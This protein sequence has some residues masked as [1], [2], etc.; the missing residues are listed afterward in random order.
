MALLFTAARI[1]RNARGRKDIL[2]RS[3]ARGVRKFS[4]QCKRKMH[5]PEPIFEV[6]L[7]LRFHPDQMSLQRFGQVERERFVDWKPIHWLEIVAGT[8]LKS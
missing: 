6:L 1:E 7:V 5:A 3:L 8:A 2:P 4:I